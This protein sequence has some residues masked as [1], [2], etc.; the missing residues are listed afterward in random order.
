MVNKLKGTGVAL[1]TPFNKDES[2]DYNSL[3]IIMEHC[4][5]GGIDYFVVLGTTGES[6]VLS[7]Q[8]KDQLLR[9]VVTQNKG[10]LPIVLGL[11]GNCTKSVIDSYNSINLDGVDAI[12]SVSPYY[13]KPSQSGIYAHYKSIS[14]SF[15]HPIIL[16]NVPGR[17]SSNI[18]AD[19]CLKLAHDFENIIAVKEA[20]GDMDQIMK[21]INDRPNDFLVLS[22]DD[23]LTLPMIF[24][25]AD[26]VISVIGQ[27]FPSLFSSMVNK[28]LIGEVEAANNFHYQ[29]YP[30][31]DPLY[32]DGNPAGIKACLKELGLC[33]STLRLPLVNVSE[34][35]KKDLVNYC[36]SLKAS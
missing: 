17:T 13:N 25:G 2:I 36:K 11:G 9:Y 24:M 12:L 26:G 3:S 18:S 29:L 34:C 27:A 14:A 5:D 20:S 19:T 15:K 35:V 22:G 8:E 31:Y 23:G 6:V 10:R 16:Y 1:I 7:N 28:G 33:K 30:I 21:I 32:K 4:I